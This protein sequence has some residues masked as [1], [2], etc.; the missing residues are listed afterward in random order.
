MSV[1]QV[2]IHQYH[3]WSSPRRTF[4]MKIFTGCIFITPNRRRNFTSWLKFQYC[5]C[6]Q[7]ELSKLLEKQIV[8]HLLHQ[9]NNTYCSI[10]TP[11]SFILNILT[12][13]AHNS[14]VLWMWTR[15]ENTNSSVTAAQQRGLCS[16]AL[17]IVQEYRTSSL[18][19]GTI[20]DG[21]SYWRVQLF[22]TKLPRNFWDVV[23]GVKMLPVS[24]L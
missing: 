12:W 8:F 7:R 4:A 11:W 13:R 18:P 24:K 3:I 23:Q 20:R 5:T 2:Q 10:H 15:V 19:K 9:I 6:S 1:D 16:C 22:H 17:Q 21:S 14:S